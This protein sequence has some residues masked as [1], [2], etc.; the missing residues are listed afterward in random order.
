MQIF[1]RSRCSF[2]TMLISS[3]ISRVVKLVSS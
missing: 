3:M 2:S 1:M